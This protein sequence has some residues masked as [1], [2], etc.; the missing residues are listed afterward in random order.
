MNG[1]HCKSKVDI[2][3]QYLQ[4]NAQNVKK[5]YSAP[6]PQ[7][8]ELL[9][10]NKVL[11]NR[12]DQKFNELLTGN[13]FCPGPNY[14]LA[15]VALSNLG[16]SQ[17]D[18]IDQYP[19]AEECLAKSL[20]DR[21]NFYG[22]IMGSV[23]L[24]IFNTTKIKARSGLYNYNPN[25]KIK[26]YHLNY[27]KYGLNY[28]PNTIIP[29]PFDV[30]TSVIPDDIMI[31]NEAVVGYYV[32]LLR[33]YIPNFIYTLGVTE[34][35]VSND[36]ICLAPGDNP[37]VIVEKPAMTLTE[38]V[39]DPNITFEQWFNI[40][41]Q[42]IMAYKYAQN[43][44][45]THYNLT[46]DN[47]SVLYPDQIIQYRVGN[48]YFKGYGLARIDNLEFSRVRDSNDNTIYG[49]NIPDMYIFADQY[50][51]L[52]DIFKLFMSS[53]YNFVFYSRT[54]NRANIVNNLNKIF[55]Y[56]NYS[57]TIDNYLFTYQNQDIMTLYTNDT[58]QIKFNFDYFY[59][60]IQTKFSRLISET[61]ATNPHSGI[62]IINSNINVPDQLW[63]NI[64]NSSLQDLYNFEQCVYLLG[65]INQHDYPDE[66]DVVVE[67]RI[68]KYITT[69]WLYPIDQN[70]DLDYEIGWFEDQ[71]DQIDDN[72][73]NKDEVY[74]DNYVGLY[75]D[76]FMKLND[77]PGAINNYDLIQLSNQDN[78]DVI[79]SKLNDIIQVFEITQNTFQRYINFVAF[80]GYVQQKYIQINDYGRDLYD[81]HVKMCQLYKRMTD[82]YIKSK[83]LIKSLTN[84]SSN[85][86]IIM[87]SLVQEFIRQYPERFG[88]NADQYDINM[89]KL[90]Y[91]H[92]N[93]LSKNILK[94]I[95]DIKVSYD[96]KLC[97]DYTGK[98][99]DENDE[100]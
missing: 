33:F 35:S 83:N 50:F 30:R 97:Q 80:N 49:I 91:E 82:D 11:Q 96:N 52:Y 4:T 31:K 43:L 67:N 92:I 7:A 62:P 76:I 46:T 70:N 51:P 24:N 85:I 56:F 12:L 44:E 66:F 69:H 14:N 34:C 9:K 94:L 20:F 5:L 75:Q 17:I 100:D 42:I 89:F 99:Y 73:L 3:Y 61:L 72:I 64:A 65:I 16:S 98:L 81:L 63:P 15:Q 55:E 68:D 39:R 25:S 26:Q 84:L 59:N 45:F 40:F 41:L 77:A 23:P 54:V 18:Q 37:Y 74:L 86:D 19:K 53:A 58:D 95:D 28:N 71:Y 48:Y 22:R 1:V 2:T 78:I 36:M 60:C 29:L 10:Y 13:A 38:Y 8:D 90:T 6:N 57:D 32:N 93:I 27:K 21:S 79:I 87:D 47:I 88:Q